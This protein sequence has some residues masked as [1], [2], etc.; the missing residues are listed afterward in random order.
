MIMN[1]YLTLS[2]IALIVLL[3][4][5]SIS[6][7]A[8]YIDSKEVYQESIQ[9]IQQVKINGLVCDFCAIALEKIFRK[10]ANNEVDTIDVNLD[11]KIVTIY[12]K[13]NQFL[14]KNKIKKLINQAG[15]NIEEFI[16]RKEGSYEENN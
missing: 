16:D 5:E 4:Q 14:A 11:S 6:N 13:P 8:Q 10:K 1:K 9:N 7:P 12:F 3:P 15:Y 2:F